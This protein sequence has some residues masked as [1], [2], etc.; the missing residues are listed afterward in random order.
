MNLENNGIE[1]VESEFMKL[2]CFQTLTRLKFVFVIDHVTSVQECEIMFRK[3]YDIYSD[4]V[5]KNPFYELDMPIRIETFES[6][7]TK[8]I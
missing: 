2:V 8:L 4:Y 3:I 1:V 6:E 7:I 5:S